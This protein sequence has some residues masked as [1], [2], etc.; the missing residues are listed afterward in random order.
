MTHKR[1]IEVSILPKLIRY[2]IPIYFEQE[3]ALVGENKYWLRVELDPTSP[4]Y[5]KRENPVVVEYKNPILQ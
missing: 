1:E 2:D 3:K 4:V 5:V